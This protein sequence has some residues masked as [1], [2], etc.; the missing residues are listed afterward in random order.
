M[1]TTH[2]DACVNPAFTPP[3]LPEV[4]PDILDVLLHDST[5]IC[6]HLQ[7]ITAEGLQPSWRN[8]CC[9]CNN[10]L[11]QS[12]CCLLQQR[13]PAQAPPLKHVYSRSSA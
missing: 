4:L 7:K 6:Y 1:N 3:L 11:A 10:K 2:A 12:S 13:V 9:S 5:R 8:H